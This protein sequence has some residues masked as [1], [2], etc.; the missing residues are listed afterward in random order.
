MLFD[1]LGS[2]FPFLWVVVLLLIYLVVLTISFTLHEYAHGRTALMEGDFTAKYEGR[3]TLNPLKHIDPIGMVCLITLG[4]GWANPVPVNPYN[5]TRGRR[6]MFNVAI[7]GIVANIFLAL[8]FSFFYALIDVAWPEFLMSPSIFSVLVNYF[9]NLGLNVNL[10]LAF[11]N[12]IPLYPLDGSKIL[13]LILGSNNKF[14]NWLKRYSNL[15]LIALLLF[16]VISY[17]LLF[18]CQFLGSGMLG[19]WEWL[20]RLILGKK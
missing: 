8:I 11:F 5:F 18:V 13:E 14:I 3:L 7:A 15:I 17:V 16:G 10:S 9:F 6:S 4:F 19:M 20:F 12:L 2:G 1:L